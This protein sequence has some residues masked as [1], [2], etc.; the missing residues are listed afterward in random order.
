MTVPTPASAAEPKPVVHIV[1]DDLSVTQTIAELVEMMGYEP[2]VYPSARAFLDGYQRTG[3]ACLVLDVRMPGM[4]G[5]ELQKRLAAGQGGLPVIIITGHGDVRMAVQAI[6]AG[7]AEFL[8]KPFRTQ[9]LSDA[10]TTAIR[11]DLAAWQRRLHTARVAEQLDRLTAAEREV[12]ELILAGKTNHMM[13]VELKLSVRAIED[14]RSRMMRK[15]G[16][17]SRAELIEW[18]SKQVDKSADGTR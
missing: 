2:R 14:R 13:A 6:Q 10:I 18:Y 15:L 8:E 4:S 12:M 16:L 5:L 17:R 9:E 3:P 11:R 7:A 1:D